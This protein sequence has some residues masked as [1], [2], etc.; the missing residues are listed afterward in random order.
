MPVALAVLLSAP[1]TWGLTLIVIVALAPLASEPTAQVT[2]GEANEQ[3]PT[4]ELAD[5]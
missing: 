2:V 5:W 1:A 3:L 4:V